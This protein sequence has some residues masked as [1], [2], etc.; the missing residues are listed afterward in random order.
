MYLAVFEALNE[1]LSARGVNFHNSFKMISDWEQAEAKFV[2]LFVFFN[3]KTLEKCF[4]F[5]LFQCTS[6]WL[7]VSSR[8][9]PLEKSDFIAILGII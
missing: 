6:T 5:C 3:F 1:E 9:S 7:S 4:Q 8:S 2:Q